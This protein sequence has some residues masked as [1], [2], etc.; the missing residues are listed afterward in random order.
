MTSQKVCKVWAR[1]V[2]TIEKQQIA[3]GRKLDEARNRIRNN[4]DCQFTD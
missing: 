3:L 2:K 1:K 4:R